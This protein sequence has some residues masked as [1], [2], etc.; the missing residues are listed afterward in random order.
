[1]RLLVRVRSLKT[2]GL[3]AAAPDP[4]THPL[5]IM[6]YLGWL[7][8]GRYAE[9]EDPVVSRWA[10]IARILFVIAAPAV[11]IVFALAGTLMAR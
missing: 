1:L 7:L 11:L 6:G 10:M 8:T 9:L 4:L 2:Q 5:E 3:A